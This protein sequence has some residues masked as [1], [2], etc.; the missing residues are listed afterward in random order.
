M[1]RPKAAPTPQWEL[2][3]AASTTQ[4]PL[5][6][7][8]AARLCFH[9]NPDTTPIRHLCPHK[10]G[11]PNPL[12]PPPAGHVSSPGAQPQ[13]LRP[14]RGPPPTRLPFSL[15]GV[16][17]PG[18]GAG[19]SLVPESASLGQPGRPGKPRPAA[20]SSTVQPRLPLHKSQPASGN[21]LLTPGPARL[22]V[23]LCSATARSANREH[24][25]LPR[26][27]IWRRCPCCAP[28][29]PCPAPA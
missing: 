27:G 17:T 28:G 26:P 12:P 18:P 25:A 21:A 1:S 2:S 10:A 8:Q 7:G 3:T 23:H 20:H 16:I 29:E 24:G 4:Q 22:A 19:P 5:S 13:A 11:S 9:G 14:L 15:R 6:E